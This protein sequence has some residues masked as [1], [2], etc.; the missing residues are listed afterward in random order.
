MAAAKDQ[1]VIV[2]LKAYSSE[3]LELLKVAVQALAE[4][5]EIQA[6]SSIYKV[7]GQGERPNHIHDLRSFAVFEGMVLTVMGIT[8]LTPLRLR[9]RFQ[10]IENRYRSEALRRSVNIHLFFYGDEA[11]MTPTLTLPDPNFHLQ[12]E[13]I[14]PTAEICPEFVHPVLKQSMRELGR[15][16]SGRNWGEFVSQGKAMLDF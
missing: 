13:N 5:V 3:G 9:E 4:F 10:E 11:I 15:P 6:I 1:A 8:E 12:A 2:G 16:Y 14:L 7:T